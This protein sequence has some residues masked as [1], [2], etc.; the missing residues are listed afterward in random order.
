[1]ATT[2]AAGDSQAAEDART[3]GRMRDI[4]RKLRE[5]IRAV[6]PTPPEQFMTVMV[7][8]KVLNLNEYNWMDESG[9][10]TAVETPTDV[11][12]REAMLVDD[13]PA[14]D[15]VQMGPTGKSI[16]NSYAATLD[17]LVPSGTTIGVDRPANPK[18][19]HD[20]QTK[21]DTA[22]KWL[23]SP[24]PLGSGEGRIER[25]T[26]Y[27]KAYSAT[28]EAK[29]VAYNEAKAK[30]AATFPAS[31][32]QQRTHYE[33]WVQEHYD[34]YNNKMQAKAADTHIAR[35]PDQI[36][37]EI[38]R[39]EYQKST[40]KLAQIGIEEPAAGG[41]GTE[42]GGT[43][44][45]PDSTDDDLDAAIKDLLK[46][47][48]AYDLKRKEV[49]AIRKP[50]QDK[51]KEVEAAREEKEEAAAK[52]AEKRKAHDQSSSS[53]IRNKISKQAESSFDKLK[54]QFAEKINQIDAQIKD[55]EAEL[56]KAIEAAGVVK[57]TVTEAL[58]DG[59]PPPKKPVVDDKTTG[60]VHLGDYWTTISADISSSTSESH[61]S[62]S[63]TSYSVGGGASWGLFS[64]GGSFSHS[65]ATRD[66]SNKMAQLSTKISFDVMRVDITRPWLRAELFYDSSFETAADEKISPGPALLSMM[67]D[68]VGYGPKTTDPVSVLFREKALKDYQLFPFYNTSFL[69]AA[70]IV[71]EFKG[72]TSDITAHFHSE[73]NSASISVGYGPFSMSG[74]YSSSSSNQDTSCVTTSEGCRITTKSPQIIGW[75]SQMMPALPRIK[76]GEPLPI[77]I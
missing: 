74:S 60:G 50:S 59:G 20:P 75:I 22:M 38:S 51:L 16:S 77:Q 37:Y 41:G 4:S 25:Y 56:E 46:K 68:P 55:L 6:I 32:A 73:Q 28:V 33:D 65:D 31:L 13:M 7:P 27:Q 14:M 42:S 24:S 53:A 61:E 9:K 8:G 71:I 10:P 12:C 17:K 64:I 58:D 52:V 35:S 29:L 1:M 57:D 3:V 36:Q 63:S 67:M 69:L 30:S 2:T 48:R 44:A 47:T 34:L 49:A 5:K 39:L 45:T 76:Q 19:V 23:S 21:Y 11:V 18:D 72:E 26:R 62:E 66:V 40:W 54:S 15:T 70:N 43:D